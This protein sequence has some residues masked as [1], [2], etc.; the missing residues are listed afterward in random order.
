[1][2]TES[3]FAAWERR[4]Q[5]RD[6]YNSIVAQ[7]FLTEARARAAWLIRD[8]DHSSALSHRV[9]QDSKSPYFSGTK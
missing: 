2:P 5:R 8:R 6:W 1:V 4:T 7:Y 3:H 9:E